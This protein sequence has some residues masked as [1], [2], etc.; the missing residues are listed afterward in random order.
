MP[1]Y[2]RLTSD[3]LTPVTAFHKIDAGRCACL[4]ESVIGGE[5]VGRYS[6]LAA[7][8]FLQLSAQGNRVKVIS[9]ER[10]TIPSGIVESCG[11]PTGHANAMKVTAADVQRC[12]PDVKPVSGSYRR[13]ASLKQMMASAER[14]LILQ[15]LADKKVLD[16]TIALA[17]TPDENGLLLPAGFTSELLAVGG[18]T[19]PGTSY[20]W[21]PFPDGGACFPVDDGGWVYVFQGITCR[22]STRM[23]FTSA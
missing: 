9:A 23:R 11:A 4:F 6:F 18:E 8:P 1:V 2:R 5:K 10:R 17:A 12:L 16:D 21:H 20:R 15:A 14:E 13:G 22:F 19:V 7:E 3:A